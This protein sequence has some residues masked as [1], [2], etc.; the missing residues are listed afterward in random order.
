[1]QTGSAGAVYVQTND[2]VRNEVVAYRRGHDGALTQ[3]GRFPTGGTG[4]GKA[5]LPSQGSL[6]LARAGE[7]LL[8]ANS[9][10]D[11]VSVFRVGD[12]LVAADRVASGGERPTS[13]AVHEEH[14]YVLNAGG[15]AN[16]AGFRLAADGKLGPIAGAAPLPDG[17]DPAQV[18][19]SPDG[20][21]LIVTDRATNSIVTFPVDAEGRLGELSVQPSN[22][23]TPYGFDFAGDVMI[24]TEAFGGEVGAAAA[25]SYRI[26]DGS[27][28]TVTGSLPNTRSEV[29]WAS[30]TKDGRYVYVTNF[31]DGTI[32]SY[33]IDADGSLD[34]LEPV[35]ASTVLGSPGVR[36]EALTGDDRFLYALDADARQ[37]FGWAVGDDGSLTPVG[38]ADGLPATAAGLAAR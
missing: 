22:G 12:S 7:L 26:A 30:A 6:V 38:S 17:S 1:M 35:A 9:G 19:F 37:V 16:L 10:S 27:L 13:I 8:V 2:A 36:D 31:G 18:A 20:T 3:A 24:V 29:C 34:L 4:T 11:D 14:V 28:A 15:Q 32:S 21:A 5:H 23:A 33:R 25:S